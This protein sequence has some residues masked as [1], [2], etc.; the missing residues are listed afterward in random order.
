LTAHNL[1]SVNPDI[2]DFDPKRLIMRS[3]YL[4]VIGL[5]LGYL[6]EKQRRLRA[7][8]DEAARLLAMVRMDTGMATNLACIVGEAMKLYHAS[9][10]LIASR[11]AG[12]QKISLAKIELMKGVPELE[13][14]DAGGTGAET[15]I[16]ENST[17]TFYAKRLAR[18]RNLA[19]VSLAVSADGAVTRP[20]EKGFLQKFAHVHP[21]DRLVSV[22]FTSGPDLSG[23]I[24][25]LEAQLTSS[26]EDDLRFLQDLVRQVGPAVYNVYLLR[27][28]RR[29]AGA[30]E[31]ARLVRELHDGA[32]QSLIGVEMQVDV[33]R[34]THPIAGSLSAE[35]ERIQHLLKEEVLKLRE[36]MQEMKSADIDARRLPG[37]LHDAVDRFQRETGIRARFVMDDQELQ[38]TQPVCRELARISQEA[39]VNVRKHSR[40]THVLVQLLES[41]GSWELIIEDD[42]AGFPFAGRL[43]QAEL[44]KTE[45]VPAV[46][47]ER[48]RLIEGQLTIES[49]PGRGAR[50][51]IR[52]ARHRQAA[53]G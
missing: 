3:V 14:L 26:A 33:L 7:E 44:D 22:A 37:F 31:R 18:S 53:H 48:V 8:K 16:G 39:L 1:P 21:F 30:L 27:R 38:L 40:A 2:A 4:T 36:L 49:R 51:E 24:F 23:R 25:L 28:L 43:T 46:I 19:F 13:W 5:M 20:I 12:S 47:R 35:L 15:F 29:R 10:A 6:A 32:V 45:R 52:V 9:R 41:S 17:T 34:R 11:E 50:V 42:G